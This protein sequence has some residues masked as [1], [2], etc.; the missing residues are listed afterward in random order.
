M[1][2]WSNYFLSNKW[3]IG[4]IILSLTNGPIFPCVIVLP[5]FPII[6]DFSTASICLLCLKPTTYL[7]IHSI[8]S[9]LALG[10]GQKVASSLN[11]MD[12]RQLLPLQLARMLWLPSW[13]IILLWNWHCIINNISDHIKSAVQASYQRSGTHACIKGELSGI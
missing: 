13:H 8:L 4:L 2:T 10:K 12:F 7:L 9:Q 1:R 5:I 3:S 11:Y 6:L